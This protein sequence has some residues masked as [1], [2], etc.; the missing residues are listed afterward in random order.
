MLFFPKAC[1]SM[2]R[3]GCHFY[4]GARCALAAVPLD[5]IQGILV[6]FIILTLIKAVVIVLV[7]PPDKALELVVIFELDRKIPTLY[8]KS[9]LLL[10][11]F[12]IVVAVA[13]AAAV[14][15]VVVVDS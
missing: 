9:G 13:A 1:Y 15:D 6:V 3:L 8:L 4:G 12:V 7:S 14:V 5:G 10:F 2:D 11:H